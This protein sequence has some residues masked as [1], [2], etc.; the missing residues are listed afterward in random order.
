MARNPAPEGAPEF[1]PIEVE[2]PVREDFQP[3]EVD[4]VGRFFPVTPD[5]V[6]E[7]APAAGEKE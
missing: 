5:P 1:Q 7:N 6:T 2:I 3:I 4:F